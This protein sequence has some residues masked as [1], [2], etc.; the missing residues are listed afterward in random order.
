MGLERESALQGSILA[1][2]CSHELASCFLEVASAQLD[3]GYDAN[4]CTVAIPTN[5]R[6]HGTREHIVHSWNE[7]IMHRVLRPCYAIE[8]NQITPSDVKD[9]N[10][11]RETVMT[12]AG[13]ELAL[14]LEQVEFVMKKIDDLDDFCSSLYFESLIYCKL[15][16][17][18]AY[19]PIKYPKR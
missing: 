19:I 17:V 5:A 14:D 9:W 1:R 18:C 13:T 2:F 15:R 8:L 11:V 6:R 10:S 16:S 3:M 12:I 7:L 4:A